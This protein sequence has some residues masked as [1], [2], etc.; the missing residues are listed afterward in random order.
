VKGNRN[1]KMRELDMNNFSEKYKN[2]KQDDKALFNA[3]II[4]ISV[5]LFYLT[6]E[7]LL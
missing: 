6:L 7:Y 5:F 1:I 3:E 4:L 2:S